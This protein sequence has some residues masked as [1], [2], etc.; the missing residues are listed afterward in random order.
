[1]CVLAQ[2]W[3]P[4]LCVALQASD[5]IA[6]RALNYTIDWLRR[7]WLCPFMDLLAYTTKLLSKSLSRQ[8]SVRFTAIL[9]FFPYSIV[10]YSLHYIDSDIHCGLYNSFTLPSNK[11][12]FLH[13]I[14]SYSLCSSL[15][16][17][18]H[19]S[20]SSGFGWRFYFSLLVC[21]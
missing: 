20:F 16:V 8:P 7:K 14:L 11:I 6:H 19:Q 12:L 13:I 1:M 17:S 2:F 18:S 9:V 5:N 3:S 21:H 15:F 10:R 4:I